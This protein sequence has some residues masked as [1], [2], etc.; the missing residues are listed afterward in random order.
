VTLYLTHHVPSIRVSPNL[1]ENNKIQGY[2]LSHILASIQ[3]RK[4]VKSGKISIN[5]E[6]IPS[7]KNGNHMPHKTIDYESQIKDI[8]FFHDSCV[9]NKLV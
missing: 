6:G 9:L 1:I 3:Q 8:N 4:E 7:L 2:M 5:T